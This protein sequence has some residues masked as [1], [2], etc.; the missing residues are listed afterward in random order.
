MKA[1]RQAAVACVLIMAGC[2]PAGHYLVPERD[3]PRPGWYISNVPFYPQKSFQCGPASL[4]S[5]LNYWGDRS[6]PDDIAKAVYSPSLKGSLGIDLWS[7]AQSRRFQAEMHTGSLR[8][9]Q[10]LIERKIPAIAFLDLGYEWLPVPHFVVVVGLDPERSMVI[11]YNGT[12]RNS[13]IPYRA[14]LRAW[15]KTHFWSLVVYPR[16]EA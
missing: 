15:Q 7:Y 5:V 14:F 12:E 2:S 4:A 6:S 11:T 9:L 10:Q 3:A 16:T 13:L 1:C 8:H